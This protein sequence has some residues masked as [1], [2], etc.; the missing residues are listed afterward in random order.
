MNSVKPREY[1]KE[2]VRQMLYKHMKDLCKYWSQQKRET[3][4]ERMLGLCHTL[5]STFDGSVGDFPAI[6]LRLST[7]PTAKEFYKSNGENWF[8]DG[9]VINDCIMASEFYKKR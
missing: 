7:H 1:T 3:E 4:E 8:K 2:E 9:M 5:L 6:D